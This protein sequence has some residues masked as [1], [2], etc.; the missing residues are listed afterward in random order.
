M[1]AT[2]RIKGL[3]LRGMLDS[4]RRLHGE[5]AVRR[6]IELLPPNL[7]KTARADL[8]VTQNWYPL[9]D[10][11]LM[12]RA[13]QVANGGDI[14]LIRALSRAAVLHDFRGIYRVLTFVMSPEFVM[15]RGPL[16]FS[17]YY[18]TGKLVIEASPGL[19]VARYSGCTGFDSLLWHD[20]IY[21]SAAVLE[22]CGAKGQDTRIVSG[23]RDGDDSCTVHFTWAA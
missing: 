13:I 12:L 18:D 2:P 8:F 6:V 7:A 9:S 19:A 17:R 10:Y 21:G 5:D 11:A 16:L 4:L 20:V 22:A 1:E 3:A 15:K 14:G 23:G